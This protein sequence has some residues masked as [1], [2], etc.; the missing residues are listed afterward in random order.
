MMSKTKS[1]KKSETLAKWRALE[2]GQNPLP[3][4]P[5]IPYRAE[6]AKY[7]SGGVRIDGPPAFVDAVLSCLKDLLAGEN[8]VTRLE[9]SRREVNND[10]KPTPNACRGSEV[11]YI[12]LHQRGR[13]GGMM[14][15]MFGSEGSTREQVAEATRQYAL[16]LG[17]ELD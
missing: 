3:L 8:G 12:R 17:V 5:V 10:F 1:T 14:A 11:C 7:G 6:G 15:A 4:M 13:E 2:P 16:A 9:L